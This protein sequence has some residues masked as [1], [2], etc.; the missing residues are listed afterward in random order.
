MGGRLYTGHYFCRASPDNRATAFLRLGKQGRLAR[1]RGKERLH[2]SDLEDLGFDPQEYADQLGYTDE[3]GMGDH[4]DPSL[5]RAETPEE[6]RRGMTRRELLVKG[7][8]GAAAL[9][10]GERSPARRPRPAR[11]ASG[12]YTGTLNMISLGV[13]WPTG[14]QAQAEKDLGVKFNVSLLSTNAQVQKSI[15]AP[16]ASISAASTTTRCSRSG[17]P[18]TSSPSTGRSSQHGT[19]TT[20]C[21]AKAGSSPATPRGRSGRVTPRSASSSSIRR[22]RRAASARAPGCR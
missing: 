21:S 11:E 22:A 15:T 20:R 12:E 8:I 10:T 18:A 14:A 3:L 6:R 2:M 1:A 7:G 17:R 16:T 9:S 13:E 4:S 5:V 19:T